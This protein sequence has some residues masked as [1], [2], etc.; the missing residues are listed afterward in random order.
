LREKQ[1]AIQRFRQIPKLDLT[2]LSTPV[3]QC[4]RLRKAI[5]G[6]PRIYI[7]RDDHIGYLCGGNKVRKLEYVM[8]E[9]LAVGA[10]TVV[11][12]GSFMSN[13]ARVTAMV[14]KRLGLECVLVLNGQKPDDPRGNYQINNLLKTT[15]V[16]V[17]SREERNSTMEDIARGLEEKGERVYKVSLGASDEIGSFGFVKA[18]EGLNSQQKTMGVRF[19]A[20]FIGSSSGGTQAGLEVGKLLFNLPDLRIFGISPD[21]PADDIKNTM[22]RIIDPMLIRL[23][24][25]SSIGPDDVVVDESYKGDGYGLSTSGSKEAQELFLE[26]EGILLD[27]VYTSKTAAALIDYC[28]RGMFSPEDNVLFWHTGGLINLFE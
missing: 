7:K 15:V 28:R 26:T 17:S 4:E 6:A 24:L 16:P 10:T 20:L 3:E 27:P 18:L 23:G 12:I 13:H 1:L 21:D 9:A 14:A 11:T 2:C 8:C 19:G 22:T 25:E 5:P